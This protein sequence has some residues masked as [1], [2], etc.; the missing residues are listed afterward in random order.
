M[1]RMKISVAT[2][3]NGYELNVNGQG[4]YYFSVEELL[5]GLTCHVIEGNLRPA[6]VR[7]AKLK[8]LNLKNNEPLPVTDEA[9]I[10]RLLDGLAPDGKYKT[11]RVKREREVVRYHKNRDKILQNRRERYARKKLENEQ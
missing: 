7:D 6:V 3:K 2:H 1:A 11:P 10:Q 8:S 5:A 4:F 9:E